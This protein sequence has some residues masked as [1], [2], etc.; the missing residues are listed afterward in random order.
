MTTCEWGKYVKR[1]SFNIWVSW[2]QVRWKRK[3][4]FKDERRPPFRFQS[5][6]TCGIQRHD[7]QSQKVWAAIQPPLKSCTSREAGEHVGMYRTRGK[8]AE[9]MLQLHKCDIFEMLYL[10]SAGF[11]SER[12]PNT[13]YLCNVCDNC[14]R[15][16]CSSAGMWEAEP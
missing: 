2:Q 9:D 6:F 4:R 3:H 5:E 11:L 1:V 15:I 8:S 12:R 10:L 14:R 7:N 13:S 16:C